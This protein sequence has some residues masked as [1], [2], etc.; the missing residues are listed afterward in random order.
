MAQNLTSKIVLRL[1]AIKKNG[2]SPCCLQVF[3]NGKR[4]VIRLGFDVKPK[5]FNLASQCIRLP[6][7]RKVEEDKMNSLIDKALAKTHLIFFE[8]LA[9]DNHLTRE[10]FTRLY[11]NSNLKKDFYKWME[12]MIEL[13]SEIR[14]P[15]TVRMYGNCLSE[16]RRYKDKCIF[17]DINYDFIAG[18]DVHLKKTGKVTNTVWR[19]H[20]DL[21]KFINL[22]IKKKVLRDNPYQDFKIKKARTEPVFLT[23]EELQ[24]LI[25][26]YDK[27]V[28]D[29][30][31]QS[32]LRQ[33]LFMCS[34][35]IRISDVRLLTEE[36]I[37]GDTIVWQPKKT[38]ESRMIQRNQLSVFAQRMI[39][40]ARGEH[41][42][43][44][45]R[46]TSDQNVNDYLRAHHGLRPR[47]N[48]RV[49]TKVGRHTFATVFL[50]CG[51]KVEV[52]QR[53]LGHS[54]IETTMVYVHISRKQQ[55]VQME[56]FDSFIELKR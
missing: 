9:F 1:D 54:K 33:F 8:A 7:S 19:F 26:L 25:K 42:Y 36:N 10:S 20:K 13:E 48:K 46:V 14:S 32:I 53:I 22:A 44:L 27:R 41:T 2:K 38:R 52:L 47:I 18:F 21:R 55:R 12:E 34:T 11:L 6:R 17:S 49:T 31:L 24:K 23:P 50:E 35:G 15:D 29:S 51:G 3:I 16:L 37:I 40:E 5:Y 45:F 39:E 30:D 43:Y 4:K 28:L 56:Q